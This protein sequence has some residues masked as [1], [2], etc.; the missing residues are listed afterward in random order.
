VVKDILEH[1]GVKGMKWG[2]RHDPGHEGQRAKTTKIARLD[3]KF[4]WNAGTFGTT[5]KIHQAAVKQVN[6]VDIPRINNKPKYKDA[7]FTRDTPL[8]RAYYKEHHDAFISALENAAKAQGVNA[9]GTKR[10]G[11]ID[12]GDSWDIILRD[13][14]QHADPQTTPPFTVLVKKDDRGFI[15]SIELMNT[16]IA[17]M[18]S[19]VEEFLSH[20]GIKGQKWGVRRK[21]PTPSGPSEVTTTAKPGRRVRTAGGQGHGASEDALA[22]ARTK[23][24]A[25]K[26]STDALSTRE[27]EALVKRMNLEQQF[28]KLKPPSA[29]SQAAKFVTD[30]LLQV[31]KQQAAKV[32]SDLATKAVENAL[33]K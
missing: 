4:E 28:N 21:N 11:I 23:Q 13:V 10:Y 18:E 22:T 33:K 1:H 8:R 5:L 25:K 27:L 20:H 19:L 31:G 24:I 2:V 15:V 6:S 29:K 32:L 17:Q 9:S 7:D 12:H 16:S 14:A 30:V 26:S 3:R